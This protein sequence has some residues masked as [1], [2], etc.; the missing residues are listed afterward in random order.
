[1]PHSD[2]ASRNTRRNFLVVRAPP[3]VLAPPFL[4]LGVLAVLRRL[5]DVPLTLPPRDTRT[6]EPSQFSALALLADDIRNVPQSIQ[7]GTIT[8][9]TN[10]VSIQ[11]S[12]ESENAQN[13]STAAIA[14]VA[15][16]GAVGLVALVAIVAVVIAKRAA[17]G[18][19][20]IASYAA[21][22]AASAGGHAAVEADVPIS[23]GGASASIPEGFF[24]PRIVVAGN[25]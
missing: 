11:S 23:T 17:S 22:P 3:A 13:L 20:V 12:Q 6:P 25:V 18:A 9:E 7:T 21:P 19:A 10:P 15:V 5:L 24:A 8:Q 16:G 14:G 2:S 1:V 4:V